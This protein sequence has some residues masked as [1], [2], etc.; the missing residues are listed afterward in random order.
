MTPDLKCKKGG[1]IWKDLFIGTKENEKHQEEEIEESTE[2]LIFDSN[3]CTQFVEEYGN[4]EPMLIV[5]RAFFTPKGQ[6]EV[7]F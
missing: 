7:L 2:E 3:G 6:N 5:N 4:R 1:K